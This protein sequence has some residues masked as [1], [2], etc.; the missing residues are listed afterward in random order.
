[1]GEV[2]D[3]KLVV[4]LARMT[5]CDW[6]WMARKVVVVNWVFIRIAQE[7]RK[8]SYLKVCFYRISGKR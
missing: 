6:R 1:M 7:G 3:W 8:A 4:K 5:R 2:G